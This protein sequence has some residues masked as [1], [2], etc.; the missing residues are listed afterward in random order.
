MVG[1]ICALHLGDVAP[2]RLAAVLVGF[3]APPQLAALACFRRQWPSGLI[4]DCHF[5]STR[6]RARS[7][8]SQACGRSGGPGRNSLFPNAWIGSATMTDNYAKNARAELADI[9]P[10]ELRRGHEFFGRLTA[11][12]ARRFLPVH[13]AGGFLG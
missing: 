8:S 1:W 4:W 11:P 2:R 6:L 3:A 13:K 10:V 7:Q 5:F 12:C 9:C